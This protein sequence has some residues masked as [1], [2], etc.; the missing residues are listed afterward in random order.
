M[1]A[2]QV[3]HCIEPGIGA[4]A[5]PG[6]VVHGSNPLG[7]KAPTWHGAGVVVVVVDVHSPEPGSDVVPAGQ[8]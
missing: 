1:S 5:P 2:V 7:E 8:A 3:W 4:T 6:H